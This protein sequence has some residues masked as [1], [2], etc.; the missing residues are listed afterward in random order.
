MAATS[1]EL[2]L[3]VKAKN[4]ASRQLQSVGRDLDHI[5]KKTS[6]L[7]K[8][9]GALKK[10]ATVGLGA[11]ATAAVASI[12]AFVS[13]D[14]KMNQSLAIMGDVSGEMRQEMSEAAREIGTSTRIGAGEAAEAYFFLASAGLDAKAAVAALPQVAAFAQAGMFDMSTATD[15][16]TD[17][18]SA[19]GLTVKDADENLKNL[20]RVTDVLVKANTLANASVEQFS[21]SLTNKAGTAL[22]LVNKDIEEG[23]AVLAVFADKGIKGQVAGENLS[24]ALKGLQIN[25]NANKAAFKRMGIEV[26]DSQGNMRNMA[27]IVEDVSGAF[28]GLS[29]QQKTS[30]LLQLGFTARQQDVI[31]MLIGTE[32]QIRKYEAAARDAGNATQ[33]VA[34]KQMKSAAAELDIFKSKVMDMGIALGEKLTPRLLDGAAGIEVIIGWL[35]KI[36]I[37][38]DAAIAAIALLSVALLVLVG[39]P[40]IAALAL[41]AGGIMLI[42]NNSK[43]NI[44]EVGEMTDELEKMGEISIETIGSVI[45]ADAAKDIAVLEV[46]GVSLGDVKQ[47]LEDNVFASKNAAESWVKVTGGADDVQIATFGLTGAL[48]HLQNQFNDSIPVTEAYEQS[49]ILVRSEHVAGRIIAESLAATLRTDLHPSM[50]KL[51]SSTGHV[52]KTYEDLN[53]ITKTLI[54]EDNLYDEGLQDLVPTIEAVAASTKLQK[55]AQQKLQAATEAVAVAQRDLTNAFLDASVPALNLLSTGR[56]YEAALAK[57]DEVQKDAESS[58]RDLEDANLGVF[59]AFVNMSGAS[60]E[61]ADNPAAIET[62]KDIAEQAGLSQ[63]AIGRITNSIKTYNDQPV[64]KKV[65]T[66]AQRASSVAQFHQLSLHQGG[67]VPG[68]PGQEVLARLEAGE[69]VISADTMSTINSSPVLTNTTNGQ[70]GETTVNLNLHGVDLTDPARRT[71][72]RIREGLRD[73]D[74]ENQ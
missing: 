55:E 8:G 48:V 70:G 30:S 3:V 1:S 9:F 4:L 6:T 10:G 31:N 12:G 11:V 35:E 40:A 13:F 17:A 56:D 71:L 15:L 51:Q 14:D 34:D 46:L 44:K 60:S 22:K 49:Q 41:V 50:E 36:P 38:T 67:V 68:S 65:F 25:A 45:G 37:S 29:D 39:H 47:G 61:F 19:L 28:G 26:F 18:Q 20:T 74:L 52:I 27:D 33:E 53:W 66:L 2:K 54:D 24:R 32:D 62:F 69:G 73:L 72:K 58:A 23:I 16:A 21:T 57:L 64:H 63:E 5:D 7:K 59:D 43:E 42:G